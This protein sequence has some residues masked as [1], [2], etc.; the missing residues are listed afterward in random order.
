[1]PVKTLFPR[2]RGDNRCWLRQST[3][4]CLHS[5]PL[6]RAACFRSHETLRRQQYTPAVP[7]REGGLC[8]NVLTT[9]RHGVHGPTDGRTGGHADQCRVG[10][11]AWPWAA[12]AQCSWWLS[13]TT[14]SWSSTRSIL[15][16]ADSAGQGQRTGPLRITRNRSINNTTTC[17]SSLSVS[18][19]IRLRSVDDV[20]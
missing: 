16:R 3:Q 20:R 4:R 15:H 7:C 14:A 6:I 8:G 19:S 1:M 13:Q 11:M 17:V 12:Q 9:A 5:G 2:F 18:C 10:C